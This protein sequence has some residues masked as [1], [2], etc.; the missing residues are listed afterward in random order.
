MLDTLECKVQT[1]VALKSHSFYL[2]Q[3]K[4]VTQLREVTVFVVA[5]K[6]LLKENLNNQD[7]NFDLQ[8][9]YIYC[10]ILHFTRFI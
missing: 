1:V 3:S 9:I 7:G 10:R 5:V 8:L 4:K 6:S 2:V